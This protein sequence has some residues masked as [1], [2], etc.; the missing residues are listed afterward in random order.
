L[1]QEAITNV[2]KHSGASNLSLTMLHGDNNIELVLQDDGCGF[3]LLNAKAW[4][5]H[6]HD[7]NPRQ[8]LNAQLAIESARNAGTKISLCLPI[9]RADTNP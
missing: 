3:D 6:S 2:L 5:R 8:R 4:A 9:A 7:A 1:T